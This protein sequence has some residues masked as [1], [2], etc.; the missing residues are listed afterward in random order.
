MRAAIIQPRNTPEP[1]LAGRIPDLQA[2]KGVGGAVEDALGD[3]GGA[4][5]GGCGG[6]I[7]G[8]LDVAVDE[9]GFSYSFAF[10]S[11]GFVGGKK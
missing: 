2:D 7:E 8:V 6:G 9:G 5:G 3:E 4:E 11:D 10:V 1:L